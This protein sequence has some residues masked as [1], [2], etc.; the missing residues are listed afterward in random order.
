M[1]AMTGHRPGTRSA[2][3]DYKRAT[4]IAR[5]GH[6]HHGKFSDDPT[7]VFE[8]RQQPGPQGERDFSNSPGRA[9][10]VSRKMDKPSRR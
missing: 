5:K 4:D 8:E 9:S 3:E 10:E 1:S 6:E 2:A 7:G